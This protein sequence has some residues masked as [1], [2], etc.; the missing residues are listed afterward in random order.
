[1]VVHEMVGAS[2]CDDPVAF[3]Q[4]TPAPSRAWCSWGYTPNWADG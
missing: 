3:P 1:M 4:D 2:L